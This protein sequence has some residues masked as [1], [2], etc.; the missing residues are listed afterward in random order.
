MELTELEAFQQRQLE[1]LADAMAHARGLCVMGHSLHC[2]ERW[3]TCQECWLAWAG[4]RA[5]RMMD[6]EGIEVVKNVSH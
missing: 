6:E 1:V 3:N 4:D 2:D 5:K